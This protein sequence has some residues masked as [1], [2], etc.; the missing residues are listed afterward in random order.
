MSPQPYKRRKAAGGAA[1][2]AASRIGSVRRTQLVTTFGPGAVLPLEE[3]A[4]MVCGID[5]WEVSEPNLFEPRLQREL[6]VRG[7]VVPPADGQGRDVPVVRFPRWHSCPLCRRLAPHGDFGAPLDSHCQDCNRELIPSRFVVAC[8]KGH[9]QDFPYVRWVHEGR[10]GEGGGHELRIETRGTTASLDD[11]VVKCSCDATRTMKGALDP[12][13][14]REVTRCFGNRPWLTTPDEECD[15]PV[16]GLQRGASNVWFSHTRSALSIPPWSQG[17]HRILERSWNVLRAVPDNALV[18]TIEG[19]DLAKHGDYSA[20]DLAAAV[21]ERLHG[22][23]GARGGGEP[24]RRQEY[25]A[26][27]RG[28][29]EEGHTDEFVAVPGA[30]A[31]R[32]EPFLDQ[33]MLVKRLREIRALDGFSR[34][35]PIEGSDDERLAP[36]FADDPGWLPAIEVRGEGVFLR[37]KADILNDWGSRDAVIERVEV[38]ERRQQERAR[39]R[40][41]P[42]EELSPTKVALHT[43]AHVLIEQFSLEAGYPT[44]S[45]RERLYVEGDQTGLLVY[46][47]TTDSAG[48]L[49]G[50]VAQAG[51]EKLEAAFIDALARTAWCSAD[52]VCLES[53]G[54]GVDSLNLAACHACSLLPE[55]SC[56]LYNV[57]LD[58]ALL[59]G[60][61]AQPELGLLSALVSG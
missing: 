41:W 14:V 18:G 51:A 21:R 59:T 9:I 60:K 2:R 38:L 26:L 55:T 34:V 1:K 25:D 31:G 29:R 23:D 22:T 45:L 30:I 57:L 15:Q 49:G 53:D 11:I 35:L 33:V 48:S 37:F 32:L 40:G 17:A 43:L 16:R 50:V 58:R 20:E 27:C 46:T 44:A 7:F 5:R 10:G 3:A 54:Q 24:L 52:P 12:W 61:P 8:T 47:A 39:S 28:K 19:L 13:A 42:V 4:F 6:N 36:L 56:E